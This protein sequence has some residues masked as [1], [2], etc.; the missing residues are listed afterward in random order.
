MLIILA[1]GESYILL[2]LC[3]EAAT[4]G[5]LNE[6]ALGFLRSSDHYQLHREVGWFVE[7][8]ALLNF[9]SCLCLISALLPSNLLL[10]ALLF[11]LALSTIVSC[12]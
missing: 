4:P 7:S 10:F 5:G 1:L 11:S 2:E 9:I 8:I 3:E 12:I 6:Q